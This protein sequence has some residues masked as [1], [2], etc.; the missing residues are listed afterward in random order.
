[1]NCEELLP[2]YQAYALGIAE[3]PERL[4]I[5]R[6]VAMNC[7][8]CVPGVRRAMETVAGMSGAVKMVDPPKHLRARV[9]AMVS[10]AHEKPSLIAFLPWAAASVLAIALVFVALPGRQNPDSSKLD[11]LLSILSDPSVK[12]VSFGQP[13]VKGRVFLS[14]DR[15]VVFVAAGLPR[16]DLH[17]TFELWVI[18]ARGNP[19]PAGTFRGEANAVVYTRPGPVSDAA[20]I[21]VTI[22]PE[23]G[24][25]Q[26]TTSPF[27]V[28]RL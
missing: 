9:I 13:A 6:H 14:P 3:D 11:Q 25:A 4:E 22:E 10:T 17:R 8:K 21:A 23:G 24:S 28:A 16:L 2:D 18:P 19:I 1:M 7:P 5:A 15:G 27:I 20:A 12:D 26:P